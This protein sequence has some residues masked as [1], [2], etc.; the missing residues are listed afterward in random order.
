MV[1]PVY[2]VIFTSATLV[3]SFILYQGLKASA[4][5]LI[6]M[7]MSFFV[8]CLGITLLQMS[9]VDPKQ[10][11]KLD[12]KAS[13]FLEA[14]HR[15]T[16]ETEKGSMS[17]MEEPGMDALRGGFGAVG[18]IIRARSINRKLSMSSTY[19]QLGGHH[20]SNLSTHG[21]E[22]LQR[23]QCECPHAILEILL[24][25][26]NDNPMPH[27]AMDQVSLHTKSPV[28][29][30]SS[31]SHNVFPPKS[32]SSLTV[33][34]CLE[35]RDLQPDYQFEEADVVH[36]Y[37]YGRGDE[38]VHG[39]RQHPHLLPPMSNSA[40]GR[41]SAS[42]SISSIYP[43]V[44]ESP[45]EY[46]DLATPPLDKR[47]RYLDPYNAPGPSN[48]SKKPPRSRSNSPGPSGLPSTSKLANMFHFSTS[49]DPSK[50][51]VRGGAHRGT[52]DYPQLKTK[53]LAPE[54]MQ[55]RRGLVSDSPTDVRESTSY[56]DEP[57]SAVTDESMGHVFKATVRPLQTTTGRA[58][59]DYRGDG[60]IT[61]KGSYA[62]GPYA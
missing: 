2:F 15:P 24:N 29:G 23:Y 14:T 54:E 30:G 7:V 48:L 46:A 25:A 37:G 21:L 52:K 38:A 20:T 32:K 27:D 50:H 58:S 39:F 4:V 36:Q 62:G 16:E 55:E 22:S 8:I 49:A 17:A 56:D 60:D 45:D 57:Q 42:N 61:P 11:T 1:V 3:T 26:V 59:G 33:S 13:I 18:S 51:Q 10:L 43:P 12:R 53:D 6:T 47:G 35:V 28:E 41:R 44:V 5:T 19:G 40:T 31:F 34:S 9:K